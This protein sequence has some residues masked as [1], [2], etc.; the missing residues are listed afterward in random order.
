[1]DNTSYIQFNV[2]ACA[3]F[4]GKVEIAKAEETN[5][6]TLFKY[7]NTKNET[8]CSDTLTFMA[9]YYQILLVVLVPSDPPSFEKDSILPPECRPNSVIT[10][11]I[12][13]HEIN[14]T[15]DHKDLR[16]DKLTDEFDNYK[17]NH[18]F[19]RTLK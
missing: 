11:E 18:V 3:F 8:N 2:S 19:T 17:P 6:K 7:V 5:S 9:D 13:F 12:D 15:T 4:G 16:D 10:L 1:M 14:F